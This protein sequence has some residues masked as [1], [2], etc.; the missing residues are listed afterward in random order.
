MTTIQG[1]A[2]TKTKIGPGIVNWA[3][4]IIKDTT[5]TKK[6]DI[7]DALND[8]IDRFNA[9]LKSK[10]VKE[11][12]E[13]DQS[14]DA[15]SREDSEPVTYTKYKGGTVAQKRAI[16]DSLYAV[17]KIGKYIDYK[18]NPA[19]PNAQS[20]G[21]ETGLC[22]RWTLNLAKNYAAGIKGNPLTNG[23]AFKGVANANQKGYW[24]A[25]ESFGYTRD[26]D[27]TFANKADLA[28]VLDDVTKFGIG[29][30]VTY[31]GTDGIEIPGHTSIFTGGY[32]SDYPKA[33]LGTLSP[34]GKA[35]KK[36]W[37]V[38]SNW[39]SDAYNNYGTSFVYRSKVNTSK[40]WRL[41]IFRAPT[42]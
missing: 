31:F 42:K 19:N 5:T 18:V 3:G 37:N 34:K 26:V 2:N 15:D 17:H 8:E 6:F 23:P 9:Y 36:Y 28:K 10:G 39:D 4:Y 20:I 13:I 27:T 12:E 1:I 7:N 30:V 29:D 41:I 24:T 25:L 33:P 16:Q 38:V 32:G 14:N 11:E 21:F 22:A 40:T 35:Y